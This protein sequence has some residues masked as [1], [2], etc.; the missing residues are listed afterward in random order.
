MP[1]PWTHLELSALRAILA[2]RRVA[3]HVN[4]LGSLI[5]L[6]SPPKNR[7][8]R[9]GGVERRR[10]CGCG[11][12]AAVRRRVMS[13][14]SRSSSLHPVAAPCSSH[15]CPR[16]SSRRPRSKASRV[17]LGFPT[18]A[19]MACP[20]S[21]HVEWL[22]WVCVRGLD[23]QK[24]RR[25]PSQASFSSS[26]GGAALAGAFSPPSSFFRH[27]PCSVLFRDFITHK[28]QGQIVWG[29][30]AASIYRKEEAESR[31]S[32]GRR[33]DGSQREKAANRSSGRSKVARLRLTR[34]GGAAACSGGCG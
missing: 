26:A 27:S 20:V 1:H 5:L 23:G 8:G 29:R 16:A 21:H 30:I 2:A 12:A 6:K 32:T 14:S 25:V 19:T 31:S 28:N 11:A 34:A 15:A 3:P 22:C 17:G 4:V 33:K 18:P 24:N 10:L 9:W 7:V 13:A